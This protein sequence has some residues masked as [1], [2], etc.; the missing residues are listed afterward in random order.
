[1]GESPYNTLTAIG[2]VAATLLT[3]VGYDLGAELRDKR[4]GRPLAGVMAAAGLGLLMLGQIGLLMAVLWLCVMGWAGL[5]F[6]RQPNRVDWLASGLMLGAAVLAEPWTALL[7][8]GMALAVG[9][10]ARHPLYLP[11]TVGI[12]ALATLPSLLQWVL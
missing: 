5:R 4:L 2:V 9:L 12:A 8:V 3:W 6:S 11:G 7:G 1:L 10:R